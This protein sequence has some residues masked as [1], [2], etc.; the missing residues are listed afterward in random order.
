MCSP[1]AVSIFIITILIIDFLKCMCVLE[2]VGMAGRCGSVVLHIQ[3]SSFM[4]KISNSLKKK[5]QSLK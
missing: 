3:E 5:C 2:Q 4:F 1:F